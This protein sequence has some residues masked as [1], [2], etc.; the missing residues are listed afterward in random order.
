MER[1][2]VTGQRRSGPSLEVRW[3]TTKS[4]R[5]SFDSVPA[6]RD[7][8]QDDSTVEALIFDTGLALD[9]LLSHLLFVGVAVDDL[10]VQA[11]E[12]KLKPV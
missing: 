11:V 8:A 3:R 4:N 6:C 12:G 2:V 1:S 5:R 10:V 7:F 9:H